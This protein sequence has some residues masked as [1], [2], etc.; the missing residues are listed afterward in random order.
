MVAR[1]V[2]VHK[3]LVRL[4]SGKLKAGLGQLK[5]STSHKNSLH[6]SKCR[7]LIPESWG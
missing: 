5:V 2:L 6:A 7:V 1:M 3:I 4:Q